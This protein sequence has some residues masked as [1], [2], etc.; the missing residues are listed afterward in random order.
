MTAGQMLAALSV[1]LI[2]A[3]TQTPATASLFFR[4]DWAT[5]PAALPITQDHVATPGLVLGLLGPGAGRVK[6]SHHDRPADDP[7]YVW[8]G[9]AGAAWVVSLSRPDA[10]VDLTVP[11]ARVRWR[12]RQTGFR[13]LHLVVQIGDSSWLVSDQSDE[14]S[15]SWREH[16]FRIRTVQW[17]E[18]DV[19]RVVEGDP[20]PAPDLTRVL[21]VG[22]TDLMRGAGTPASSRLD[23]IEVYGRA[24]PR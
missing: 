16:E 18:L 6:K 9:E 19:V 17:R 24:R 20:V 3:A 13:R 21:A 4:E 10:L 14:A 11:E 5:T 23:W 15:G 22:F 1:V 8:S 7:Y 12:A 2:M